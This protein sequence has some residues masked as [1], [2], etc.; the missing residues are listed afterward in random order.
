ME[1]EDQ[2]LRPKTHV[3]CE[4]GKESQVYCVGE[5][6]PNTPCTDCQLGEKR[7]NEK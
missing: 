7:K 1:A 5:L 3:C 4:C 6:L 2:Q